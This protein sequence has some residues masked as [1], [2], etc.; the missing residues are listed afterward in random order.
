MLSNLLTLADYEFFN[1]VPDHVALNKSWKKLGQYAHELCKDV[2]LRY[3]ECKKKLA[4]LQAEHKDKSAAHDLLLKDYEA[5]LTIE[6]ALHDRVDELEDEKKEWDN[7]QEK[8]AT[9]IKQL[10]TKLEES[11]TEA[12]QLRKERKD[13][14]A[15]CGLGQM[16]TT[17]AAAAG[18]AAVDAAVGVVVVL[19]MACRW[20]RWLVPWQRRRESADVSVVVTSGCSDDGGLRRWGSFG[21]V[22]VG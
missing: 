6:K 13:F 2:K 12:H 10:E 22:V 4:K 11:V 17:T 14:A 9:R 3:N 21:G 8:Q 19:V 15:K 1:G 20:S 5:A 18:K 16:P 7:T